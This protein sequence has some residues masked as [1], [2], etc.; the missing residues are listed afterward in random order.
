MGPPLPCGLPISNPFA[1]SFFFSAF[2]FKVFADPVSR[3][4]DKD[5]P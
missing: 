5:R 3:Q 1:V 4:L 2:H